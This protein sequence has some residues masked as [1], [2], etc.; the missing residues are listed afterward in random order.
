M[1]EQLKVGLL[2][3][4]QVAGPH[5]AKGENSRTELMSSQWLVE[6]CPLSGVQHCQLPSVQHGFDDGCGFC[7]MELRGGLRWEL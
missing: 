2:Q 4:P 5:L 3:Y 7:F 6:R 1:P